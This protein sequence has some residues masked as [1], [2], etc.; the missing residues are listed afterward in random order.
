MDILPEGKPISHAALEPHPVI[1]FRN[2]SFS[3]FSRGDFAL[4]RINLDIFKGQFVIITGPSGCGKSTLAAAMAGFIPQVIQ[5]NLS[6]EITINGI[7]TRTADIPSLAVHAS[8]CQQDPEA[9]LCTLSVRDEVAFGPENLGLSAQEVTDR[10]REALAA[11]NCRHLENRSV[12]ELSGGEKQRVVIASMLA[13]QSSVIILDEPTSSQDPRSADEVMAAVEC[14]RRERK[15]TVVVIEHRLDR[16]LRIADRLIVMDAGSIAM[17]GDPGEVH[18]RCRAARDGSAGCRIS[19][20]SPGMPCVDVGDEVIRV[21]DLR[22]SYQDKEVLHGVS[23]AA[24][25][26]NIIGIIGPNGSGKTTF[27]NC[28]AGLCRPSSGVVSVNGINAAKARVSEVARS[29]GFVFQNPNHQIFENSVFAE[30]MFACDNFGI[31]R[32]ISERSARAAMQEYGISRYAQDSPLTLSHGEKRRLN[33][34]ATLP[35]D[36]GIIILDE[37][38]T[39]QDISNAEK[40]MDDLL[41]L[42]DAGKTLLIVSHDVD[43]VFRYCDRIVFFNAGLIGAD[44]IPSRAIGKIKKL[45]VPHFLPRTSSHDHPLY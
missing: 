18:K 32:E 22:F 25:K 34:C 21:R 9:Q 38:F 29:I 20:R 19:E 1:S 23:F 10:V 16:L 35:H 36:P 3:F 28:L 30:V 39:G 4:K 24:H 41:R 13:M 2:V 15:I 17:D 8:L 26:G 6:G 37:P 7:S 5:G 42:R 14:L 43:L 45:G 12:L 31:R 44:D 27:L 33:I 11:T 40:I